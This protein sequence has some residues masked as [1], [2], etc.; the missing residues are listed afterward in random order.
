MTGRQYMNR[1]IRLML[2]VSPLAFV[3]VAAA[4]NL[5]FNQTETDTANSIVLVEGRSSIVQT[6]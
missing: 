6:P 4:A 2:W 1:C 5:P 3:V